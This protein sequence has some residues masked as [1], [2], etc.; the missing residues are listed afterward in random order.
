MSGLIFNRILPE[1]RFWTG[2]SLQTMRFNSERPIKQPR[3]YELDPGPHAHSLLGRDGLV[4]MILLKAGIDRL[5]GMDFLDAARFK[6]SCPSAV[7]TVIMRTA[8]ARVVATSS[9]IVVFT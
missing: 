5:I 7:L 9:A 6:W 3:A 8:S 1:R 4:L 2:D